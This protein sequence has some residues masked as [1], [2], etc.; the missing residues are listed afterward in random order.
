MKP[1]RWHL[2]LLS[3]SC[4]I[5]ITVATTIATFT[6]DQCRDL[7][8]QLQGQNGYPDGVCTSLGGA[9]QY[10]SFKVIQEDPGC[11]GISIPKFVL[12]LIVLCVAEKLTISP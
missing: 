12:V 4:T 1:S 2:F 7:L 10:K 5:Q 6:D 8:K 3:S 9:G 11:A